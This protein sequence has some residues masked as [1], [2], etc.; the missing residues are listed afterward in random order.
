MQELLMDLPNWTDILVS[1][2]LETIQMVIPSTIIA[3]IMGLPLG[4]L[5]T[6]TKKEGIKP[7]P[8]LNSAL[9]W[10]INMMRSI[11]FIILLIALMP[12]SRMLIGTSIGTTAMI[13]P[14]VIASSPFVARMVESTLEEIDIGLIEASRAMGA[15]TWQIVT[16]VMIPE[17]IPSLVRG[18][19]ISL[20]TIIGYSALAGMIGGGG[21][22]N[23]AIMYG[24]KR[25]EK[26]V[27]VYTIVILVILVQVIQSVFNLLDK[28]IDKRNK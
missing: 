10:F 1:G 14:L 20:I 9:G 17:S 7:M 19:S 22:G 27:L 18:F 26:N 25:T 2:I 3:Y 24:H 23:V 16:K 6:I 13:I 21:I 28:K 15:T 4:V 12:L 5:I 8:I 11:P